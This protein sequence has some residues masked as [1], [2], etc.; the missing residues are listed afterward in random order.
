MHQTTSGETRKK[1]VII[2]IKERKFLD[3]FLQDNKDRYEKITKFENCLYA[4]KLIA[5]PILNYINETNIAK[6]SKKIK[7]LIINEYDQCEKLYPYLGEILVKYYHDGFDKKI[8]K[9]RSFSKREVRKFIKS[10]Q[11]ELNKNIANL[12]FNEFS[13]EYFVSVKNSKGKEVIVEKENQNIFTAEYDFDYFENLNYPL[14][15]YRFLIVDGVIDSV[16]E[17]HHLLQASSEDN[18]S[19]V[20]FCRGCHPEVKNTILK[21]NRSGVTNVFL[22]CFEIN[23]M[24]INV[25][26]DIAILHNT[27]DIVSAQKGQTI[28]QELRKNLSIGKYIKF[29]KGGIDISPLCNELELDSHKKSIQKRID[30]AD[31]DKNKEVLLSRYRNLQS[32]K[33][34]IYIPDMYKAELSFVKELD[35]LLRF[36][37]NINNSFICVDLFGKNVYIPSQ[38]IKFVKNK[39]NAIN[40]TFN[41]IEY[42]ILKSE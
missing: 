42:I 19:Y 11:Y 28:S 38:M 35:Y 10:L 22:V 14:K 34:N 39:L 9:G 12:I 23:E 32:K 41:N 36:I 27:V 25:L 15:N 3:N 29:E 6:D 33:L 13:T 8:Y 31:N 4:G 2:K 37:S 1:E 26:N 7:N 30:K 21:N 24:N 20:L 40:K 5:S 18:N 16:G 17:I